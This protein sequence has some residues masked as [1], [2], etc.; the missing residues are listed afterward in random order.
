MAKKTGETIIRPMEPED[1]SAIL[2]IDRKI[3]GKRRAVTY[4]DLITGDLGGDLDLSFVA[5]VGSQVTGFI[6]ARRAY[7]VEPVVEA[8]LIQ[9][10]GVDPE[11]QGQGIATRLVNAML[12]R[13]QATGLKLV[14]ISVRERDSQLKGFFTHA[15]FRRGQHIDYIK[16][17]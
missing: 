5:E 3:R 9:V 8:G 14:R 17:L 1:I 10:L 11:F 4:A 2:E 12:G 15:G 6:L 13:C 16:T 7:T